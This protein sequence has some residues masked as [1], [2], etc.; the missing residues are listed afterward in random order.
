[1]EVSLSGAADHGISEV[2]YLNDPDCNEL[3]LYRDRA[4]AEWPRDG[5]GNLVMDLKPLDLKALLAKV[6]I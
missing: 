5:A 1:M 2:V 4:P 6:Q 3:E